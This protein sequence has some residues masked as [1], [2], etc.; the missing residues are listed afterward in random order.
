MAISADTI[1]DKAIS[2]Q[3]GSGTVK[4]PPAKRVVIAEPD[5]REIADQR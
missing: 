2:A 1:G 5:A 4:R 3:G